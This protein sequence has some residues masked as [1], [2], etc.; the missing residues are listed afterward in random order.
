MYAFLLE[1]GY[2]YFSQPITN[3]VPELAALAAS[4]SGNAITS[5]AWGDVTIG[6]LASHLAGIASDCE[7]IQ[8]NPRTI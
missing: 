5:V 7:Y 2:Q 4:Q 6:D 1:A 8:S 3:F